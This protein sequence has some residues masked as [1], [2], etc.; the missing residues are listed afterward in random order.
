MPAPGVGP[1]AKHQVPVHGAYSVT[2]ASIEYQKLYA[3]PSWEQA[4][5]GT[6]SLCQ[7]LERP[8]GLSI[9]C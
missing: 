5:E 2:L 1:Q 7:I 9:A 8:E 3:K 4:I 6:I